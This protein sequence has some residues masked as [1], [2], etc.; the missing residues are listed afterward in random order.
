MKRAFFIV[1]TSILSVVSFAQSLDDPKYGAGQVPVENGKV[2]FVRTIDFSEAGVDGNQAFINLSSKM[3][4]G[5]LL[6]TRSEEEIY[7]NTDE[8]EEP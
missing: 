5:G 7:D 8:Y 3:E 2:T 4:S 6:P 1:L